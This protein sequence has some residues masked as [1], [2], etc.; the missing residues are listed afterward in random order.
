MFHADIFSSLKMIKNKI[1]IWG[2]QYSYD[3]YVMIINPTAYCISKV[4]MTR[5]AISCS[6]IMNKL[7]LPASTSAQAL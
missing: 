4:A 6:L 2:K 3:S 7:L 1:Y 5:I